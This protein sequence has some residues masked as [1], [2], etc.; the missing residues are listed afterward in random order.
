MKNLALKVFL[1]SALAFGLARAQ[2]APPSGAPNNIGDVAPIAVKSDNATFDYL[3]LDAS[4]NLKVTS[5]SGGS[6]GTSST[7]GAAFPATGTA[8]GAKDS[9][10]VNMTF[11]KVNSANAL[12]VDGSA[13]T[14]PVSLASSV[15]VTGTFWQATQPVSGTFWQATQ[16]V[17]IAT[18]PSLAAGAAV[19]GAVTQSG[20]WTVQPGN[21]ANTTA[22]KV[23][24]SAVT[25]PVSNASLPLPAGAS[26]SAKQPALGTAGTPSTDVISIQGVASG[27]VLPIVLNDATAS[28]SITTQNLNPTSG[29]A[30]AGSTVALTGLQGAGSIT[31]G[32]QGTYTG[33]LTVQVSADGSNWVAAPNVVNVATAATSATIAS[34]AVGIFQV[35]I[36]T[37]NAVRVTALAAVTGTATVT[38]RLGVSGSNYVGS[39]SQSGTWTVA[40]DPATT[41][42]TNPLL[43]GGTGATSIGKAEDAPSASGDTGVP[44]WGIRRDVLTSQASAAGDYNEN[45]VNKYGAGYRTDYERAMPTYAAV[46]NASSAAASTDI[47]IL[48]GN[49]TNTVY[50]TK[51]IVSG[52]Q[53]SAGEVDILLV[54]RSTA[55]TGGTSAAMTAVPFDSADAAASSAPLSFTA[56][57]TLGT[58]V[59]TVART[60]LPV[61][62]AATGTVSSSYTF[63]FGVRGKPIKLSGTAQGLAVNLN[64]A[65]VTGG[66]FTVTYEWR[67]EP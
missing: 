58:T 56:N 12:V 21:T 39:V 18:L 4:G 66:A 25:Q 17:S 41:T 40:L 20:T 1:L 64:G 45:A 48:P 5:T 43:V 37:M 46:V 65:T 26:T 34:A 28:G 67:E 44:V 27:T 14:Q 2:P 62:P 19:I 3:H 49:A 13:V 61:A 11:M 23:D 30:T 47:T 15:A 63:D 50:V 33:A 57:P 42:N 29:T 6:G 9:T 38:A 54:K 51:V 35:G 60:Y 22:W 55:D 24:G 16:P 53:T 36:G 7:F 52:V 32:V 10:G 8:A 31:I 59:G